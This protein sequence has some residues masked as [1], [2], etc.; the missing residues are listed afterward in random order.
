VTKWENITI[1]NSVYLF[2]RSL[3]GYQWR[4]EVV[5]V[6]HASLVS[7]VGVIQLSLLAKRLSPAVVFV[8]QAAVVLP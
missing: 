1:H 8:C 3:F 6:H 7:S 5:S 2:F 4:P